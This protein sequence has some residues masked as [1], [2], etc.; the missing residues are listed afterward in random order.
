MEEPAEP[1]KKVIHE[2]GQDLSQLSVFELKERVL[3]LTE[4]IARI[5]QAIKRKESS[6]SAADNFFKK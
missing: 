1:Q 2:V 5:E 4:E 6:K 3:A